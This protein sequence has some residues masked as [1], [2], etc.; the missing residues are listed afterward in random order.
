MFAGREL[1]PGHGS[2]TDRSQP[3]D[4]MGM[5]GATS[6]SKKLKKRGQDIHDE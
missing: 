2:E 4:N 5:F 3:L 1:N 6:Y